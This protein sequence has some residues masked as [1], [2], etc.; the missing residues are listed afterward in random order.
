MPE[1]VTLDVAGFESV[2]FCHATPRDD[3]EVVLVDSRLER[4]EQVLSRPE[5][6]PG[7]IH[8]RPTTN[9]TRTEWRI[10]VLL[11]H[12]HHWEDS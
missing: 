4:W 8:C 7:Q 5:A 6:A 11:Q 1:R 10:K 9:A 12:H 3:E 2:L